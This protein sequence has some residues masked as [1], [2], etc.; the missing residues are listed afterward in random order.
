M[1]TGAEVLRT[2]FGKNDDEESGE[3]LLVTSRFSQLEGL[4]ERPIKQAGT[5]FSLYLQTGCRKP[6]V[7][8]KRFLT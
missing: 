2:P 3:S 6:V 4:L 7:H 8:M 5:I 1:T